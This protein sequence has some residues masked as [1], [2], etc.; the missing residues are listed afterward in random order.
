MNEMLR[1]AADVIP[2]VT[3][4]TWPLADATNSANE[5]MKKYNDTLLFN[6]A[7]KV[8]GENEEAIL[9][10][11][12]RMGLVDSATVTA[13]TNTKEFPDMLLE[14]KMSPEAYMAAI[15]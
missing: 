9:A 15:D 10:L 5:A 3:A 7:S 11:A 13:N 12:Q 14:K 8:F 6:L 4:A 1:D 2:P